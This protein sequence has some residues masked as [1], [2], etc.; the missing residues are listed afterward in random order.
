MKKIYVFFASSICNMGGQEQYL[1]NKTRRLLADGFEVYL[2]SYRQGHV[3][4]DGLQQFKKYV[5]PILRLEPYLYRSKDV[6]AC[7]EWLHNLV[8]P[9]K[10][11]ILYVESNVAPQAEWGELFAQKVGAKHIVID[12]QEQHDYSSNLKCFLKY[13]YDRGELFGITTKSISQI[14]G[15]GY[16]DDKAKSSYIHAECGGVIQEIEHPLVEIFERKNV[17][18]GSIGRLDKPYVMPMIKEIVSFAKKHCENSIGLLLIGGGS[19][20][21]LN[22]IQKE[23][24]L[25][26]NISLF[27]TGYLCPIP[28]KLVKKI[29]CFVSSAGSAIETMRYGIP[30]IACSM[31]TCKPLGILDYTIDRVTMEEPETYPE[32]QSLLEDVLFN[33]FCSTHSTLGKRECRRDYQE[34]YRRQMSFFDYKNDFLYYDVSKIDDYGKKSFFYKCI[35]TIV[36]ANF[37]EKA[38]GYFG[39]IRNKLKV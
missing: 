32:M 19:K 15:S 25:A 6:V 31:N 24:S 36:G 14:L 3:L 26:K 27:I 20:E 2:F 8:N 33:N 28:G 34:E 18:I 23:I 30:T 13:K 5:N 39:F 11:D 29:D 12:L 17:N 1:N 7:L 16:S 22:E 9:Q 37:F 4:L 21:R 35:A 38:Q 10:D